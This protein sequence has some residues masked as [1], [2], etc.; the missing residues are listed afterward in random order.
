[1]F[2]LVLTLARAT[3]EPKLH[4][5]LFF[6]NFDTM[7]S[8]PSEDQIPFKN[9]LLRIISCLTLATLLMLCMSVGGRE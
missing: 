2:S 4:E 5:P 8:I 3:I 1:M 6:P 7:G 9:R